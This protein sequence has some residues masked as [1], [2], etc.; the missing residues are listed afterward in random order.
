MCIRDRKYATWDSLRW[1]HRRHSRTASESC[2]KR[3]TSTSQALHACPPAPTRA[4]K[5][6]TRALSPSA[7]ATLRSNNLGGMGPGPGQCNASLPAGDP[8]QSDRC[9]FNDLDPSHPYYNKMGASL[10]S[11]THAALT[12]ACRVRSGA[13]WRWQFSATS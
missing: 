7:E 11:S 8:G 9:G 6:L 4:L 13:S 2:R 12:D 10:Y 5:A 3:L 1:I